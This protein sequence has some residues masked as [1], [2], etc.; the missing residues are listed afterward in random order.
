MA[1]LALEIRRHEHGPETVLLVSGDLD[2]QT[3]ADLQAE[4]A[5]PALDGRCVVV[6]LSR[7]AFIDSAGLQELWRGRK[8]LGQRSGELVLTGIGGQPAE[9][10]QVTRLGPMFTMRHGS[11]ACGGDRH[12]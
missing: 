4:L 10:L 2:Y 11:H 5:D 1:K 3:A 9:L 6:D 7:L 12:A 8:S